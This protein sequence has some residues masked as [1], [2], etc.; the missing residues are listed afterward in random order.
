MGEEFALA[1]PDEEED[2][3]ETMGEEEAEEEVALADPDDED[4]EEEEEETM[5]EEEAI[6][7]IIRMAE[8]VEADPEN[9]SAVNRLYQIRCTYSSKKHEQGRKNKG[10]YESLP[11]AEKCP[12]SLI[13]HVLNSNCNIMYVCACG[14]AY[15]IANSVVTHIRRNQC[16]VGIFIK[17]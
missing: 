10:T 15:T 4:E 11:L 5:G 3:E 1:D 16:G 9:L 8:R 12:S 13:R 2:E 17:A 14:K 6:E 7:E